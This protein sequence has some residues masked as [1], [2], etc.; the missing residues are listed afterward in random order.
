MPHPVVAVLVYTPPPFDI[1][2][3]AVFV[4]THDAVHVQ[5]FAKSTLILHAS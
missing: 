2:D 4:H 5:H 3:F 1:V